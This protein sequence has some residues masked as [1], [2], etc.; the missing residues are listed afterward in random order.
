MRIWIL[1]AILLLPG[2]LATTISISNGQNY[3][4]EDKVYTIRTY[5]DDGA[6]FEFPGGSKIL[7][8]GECVLLKYTEFCLSSASDSSV[9]IAEEFLGAVLE[10]DH[11]VESDEEMLGTVTLGTITVTN[12]GSMT[13]K[14]VTVTILMP[15]GLHFT[16]ETTEFTWTASVKDELERIYRFTSERNGT[17]EINASATYFDG[18]TTQTVELE[19]AEYEVTIP[20]ET[21][22]G[23]HPTLANTSFEV[24]LTKDTSANLSITFLLELPP[25]ANIISFT[26]GASRSGTSVSYKQSLNDTD[27][28]KTFAV[29]YLLTDEPTQ[30]AMFRIDYKE[31]DEDRQQVNQTLPFAIHDTVEPSIAAKLGPLTQNQS[32]ELLVIVTGT[33]NGT[34]T[35]EGAFNSSVS[36]P[37]GNYSL[38]VPPLDAGNHSIT[39]TF[40]SIDRFANTDVARGSIDLAVLPYTAIEVPQE[41]PLTP[42]EEEV[43]PPTPAE[44]AS[45]WS[46]LTL[47]A[48]AA[49]V[50]LAVLVLLLMV[51]RNPVRRLEKLAERLH[52]LRLAM[53]ARSGKATEKEIEELA[54][55]QA[56]IERLE[57]KL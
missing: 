23:F 26:R 45:T 11:E 54:R 6:T 52:T 44:Q 13:A 12:E 5:S 36:G 35:I 41:E 18:N 3:T 29:R 4:V 22:I 8:E 31:S 53:S 42:Q 33:R 1:C 10:F 46:M 21:E 47:V 30:D 32:G 50:A 57:G 28:E 16:D 56:E 37:A 20:F 48:A 43:P 2:V 49:V 19:A 17:F 40:T 39:I 27:T 34:L 25:E 38:V 24:N 9:S 15:D 14:N 51:F 55:I 7:L